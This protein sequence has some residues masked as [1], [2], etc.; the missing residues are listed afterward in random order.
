MPNELILAERLF[1]AAYSPTTGLELRP[2]LIGSGPSSLRPTVAAGVIA[3]LIEGGHAVLERVRA[4]PYL[5]ADALLVAVGPPPPP[6]PLLAAAHEKIAG[7]STR[8]SPAPIPTAPATH[9]QEA[10]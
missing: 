7:S 9:Q 1:L 4:E 8:G 10:T 5:V 3:D 2:P 6:H